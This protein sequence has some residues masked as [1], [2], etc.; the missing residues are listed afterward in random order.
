M[1]KKK[2]A[3]YVLLPVVVLIWGAFLIKLYKAMNLDPVLGAKMETNK[4][5]KRNINN[6]PDT[7][8]I[9]ANYRDPFLGKMLSEVQHVKFRNVSAS[10]ILAPEIKIVWPAIV[11]KGIIK[12][13]K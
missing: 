10:I 6:L 12:N 2:L 8:S 13:K 9:V 11:Y 7:F 3:I 4:V 5:L 1:D